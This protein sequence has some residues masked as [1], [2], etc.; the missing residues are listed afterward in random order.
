MSGA[1]GLAPR[2]FARV[3]PFHILLDSEMRVVQSGRVVYRLN[4]KLT[5]GSLFGDSFEVQRPQGVSS[6]DSF[7]EHRADLFVLRA[8]ESGMILRGGMEVDDREGRIVFLG[9]P[10]VQEFSEAKAL[11]LSMG[12]FPVNSPIPDFLLNQHTLRVTLRDSTKLSQELQREIEAKEEYERLLKS[13]NTDLQHFARIAAHD[14]RQ[15]LR[16]LTGFGSLLV[17]KIG[18]ELDEESRD[19]LDTMIAGAARMGRLID[20]LLAFSRVSTDGGEF[21]PSDFNTIIGGVRD[22]LRAALTESEG[23]LTWDEL[24]T[25]L[26]DP[27]QISQ[28]LQNLVSNALK[29]HRAGE[30]PRVHVSVEK[31]AGSWHFSVRD[32]GIGIDPRFAEKVFVIFQRLHVRGVYPGEGVGLSIVQRIVERHEGKVWF[33]SQPGCGST[34]H[35]TL[36]E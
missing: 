3:F 14:L 5:P 18:A 36:P 27:R 30:P 7:S 33:D 20:G 24:P 6:F 1:F 15:P 4:P 35:F 10:W 2:L 28:V 17:D 19:Y 11:G 29:F 9:E 23:R 13:S 8:R 26:V 25:V 32:N 16:T 12:D 21:V 34:F 31:Q 22:A